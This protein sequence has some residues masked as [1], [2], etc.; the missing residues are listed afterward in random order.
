LTLGQKLKDAREQK[1]KSLR[2]IERE[3]GNRISNGYLSLLESNAVKQPSPI[4]LK[5][6]AEY[7][8]LD[9]A[10][11][12]VLAGYSPPNVA[13]REREVATKSSEPIGARASVSADDL[14]AEENALV[15]EYVGL[16]RRAR[17]PLRGKPPQ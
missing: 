7:F 4:H 5:L 8:D 10:E 13:E 6:L 16:L 15:E 17:N 12:M 9:Y 1:R 14:T 11:L 3:T 2:D